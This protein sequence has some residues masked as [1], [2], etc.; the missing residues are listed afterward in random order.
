MSRAQ[1]VAV[2]LVDDD[3]V[4]VTRFT[5]APDAETGW[6]THGFDYVIT[7]VTDC[8]MRLEAPDG[9]MREVLVPAGEAYR[10]DAGVKHNVINA[11]GSPMIFVETELKPQA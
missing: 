4:R 7:A 8:A 6:H 9:T 3:D 1:A 5:F 2:Q 11:G 10:R